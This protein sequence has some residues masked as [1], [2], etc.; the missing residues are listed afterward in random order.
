MERRQFVT[1]LGTAGVAALAGCTG[2]DDDGSENGAANGS[3]DGNGTASDDRSGMG[4]GDENGMENGDESEQSSSELGDPTE[5]LGA[6]IEAARD[7]EVDAAVAAFHPDHP[8]HPDNFE[9]DSEWEFNLSTED[10]TIESFET[11]VVTESATVE[12]IQGRILGAQLLVDSDRASSVIENQPTALVGATMT[13]DREI[14]SELL[15]VVAAH[16]GEWRLLW[17]GAAADSQQQ[18]TP[19]LETRVVDEV[20]F[21]TEK[22]K[23]R[24]QFVESPVADSVTV[25]TT[26]PED[27]DGAVI[28]ENSTDTPET[29]DW[30]DVSVDP[31]GD[32]VLVRATVDG[33]SRLVHRERYP[34][35][36]R[37]VDDIVYDTDVDEDDPFGARARVELTDVETEGKLR[38]E[39]TRAGGEITVD[40][41]SGVRFVTVT[42]DGDGDEVTVFLVEDGES[43]EIHRE[44][45]HP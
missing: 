28:T 26:G 7:G 30:L 5:P 32:E 37:L 27:P 43:E 34:P 29:V 6:F 11:R 31:E 35:S 42:I 24:V 8:F 4:N 12:D 25:E 3:D 17:Q 39:S 38:A 45:Y 19:A 16:E 41:V 33:E 23:A 20:T 18:Q 13:T 44:R 40:S 14:N 2:G 10:V 22:N 21:N 9:D 1:A 36:E 15:G